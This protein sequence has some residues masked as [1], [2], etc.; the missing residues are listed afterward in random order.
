[1]TS[2]SPRQCKNL[3]FVFILLFWKIFL[4]FR[5]FLAFSAFAFFNIII[6]IFLFF[7]WLSRRFL[8]SF[9]YFFHVVYKIA[10]W[11]VLQLCQE[12]VSSALD[13]LIMR[14]DAIRFEAGVLRQFSEDKVERKTCD[15]MPRIVGA[16]GRF[17]RDVI[18]PLWFILLL[19]RS[20][21][22]HLYFWLSTGSIL[23]NFLNECRSSHVFRI[24][25][26]GIPQEFAHF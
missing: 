20:R 7:T 19:V 1:M 26:W 3:S 15:P 17:S 18:F 23:E 4:F 12:R 14:D 2:C 6:V 9:T 24:A 13:V 8:F 11:R 25:T 16:C 10:L 22:P 5:V 21:Y